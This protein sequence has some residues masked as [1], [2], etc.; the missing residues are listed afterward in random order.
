MSTRTPRFTPEHD[1]WWLVS[2]LAAE[3]LALIAYFGLTSAQV[4]EPRYMLYPLLWIAVGVWA[5]LRVDP[6]A[7]SE[8]ARWAAGALAAVYVLALAALTGLLAVYLTTGE[9]AHAHAHTH[10]LS[11]TMAPPGWGPRIAFATDLF[12]V[13]VVPFRVVGYLALGYLL[14]VNALDAVTATVPGLLGVATCLSCALPLASSVAGTLG[15]AAL[16]GAVAT[17]SL[18][19]STAAFLLAAGLLTRRPG[20]RAEDT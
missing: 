20:R 15:G 1:A 10:G 9:A 8:H 3:F 11:I 7:A 2:L 17:Y 16:A 6:P 12:H 5:V 19:I 13:Y 14:Y 18:D 4:T